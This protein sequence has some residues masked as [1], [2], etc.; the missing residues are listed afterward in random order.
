MAGNFKYASNLTWDEL[1]S[2]FPY[3][4]VAMR[5]TETNVKYYEPEN[6]LLRKLDE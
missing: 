5:L 6:N 3:H 2:Q 1:Y 4:A